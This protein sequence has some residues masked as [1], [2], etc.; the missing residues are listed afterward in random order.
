M[1]SHQSGI[2]SQPLPWEDRRNNIFLSQ[3]M[4]L[5]G[6]H[7]FLVAQMFSNWVSFPGLRFSTSCRS[8]A[9]L[10]QVFSLPVT[11][12]NIVCH[13]LF[14]LGEIHTTKVARCITVSLHFS[15]KMCQNTSESLA[16]LMRCRDFSVFSL[17]SGTDFK[18]YL[19]NSYFA[20]KKCS[21][22]AH[23]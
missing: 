20:E 22:N 17:I 10:L 12:A 14:S 18:T 7:R 19:A 15:N 4:F 3:C 16:V 11:R 13:L 1:W 5:V 2:I 9:S 6:G 23:W 8:S 21:F